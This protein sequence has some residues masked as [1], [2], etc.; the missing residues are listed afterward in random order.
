M[1]LRSDESVGFDEQQTAAR[2][3]CAGAAFRQICQT[4][5]RFRG[6]A[7]SIVL[8]API[9]L[10][11]SIAIKLESPGPIVVR[12]TQFG[13]GKRTIRVYKFRCVAHRA[14]T[15]PLLQRLT[16]VGRMLHHT[17]IG[18]LPQLF[19][20]LSGDL[21]IVGPRP[22]VSQLELAECPDTPLLNSIKPGMIDWACSYRVPDSGTACQRRSI[23]C[24]EPVSLSGHHVHLHGS[25]R[26]KICEAPIQENRA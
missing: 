20:V 15:Q 22:Y 12:E 9:L 1:V 10:I 6:A 21:S 5:I 8:F 26:R 19:S 25:I 3:R 14:E 24:C 4:R 7:F 17:G 23:L 13:Y 16:R 18:E 11:T 2:W